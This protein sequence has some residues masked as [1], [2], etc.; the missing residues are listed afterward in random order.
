MAIVPPPSFLDELKNLKLYI[1]YEPRT[2]YDKVSYAKLDTD[3]IDEDGTKF[4]NTQKAII[5]F[6]DK[7][8]IDKPKIDIPQEQIFKYDHPPA[9]ILT[10]PPLPQNPPKPA[11]TVA[12]AVTL[13]PIKPIKP[14]DY[15]KDIVVIGAGPVGLWFVISLLESKSIT[16]IKS[17]TVL[18]KRKTSNYTTRKQQFFIENE[19][20]NKLPEDIKTELL[21]DPD[22]CRIFRPNRL[23]KSYCYKPATGFPD[24]KT[25]TTSPDFG[26]NDYINGYSIMINKLQE[27]FKKYIDKQIKIDKIKDK[28]SNK[29]IDFIFDATVEKIEDKKIVYKIHGDVTEKNK[30]FDT[31]VISSGKIDKLG[32]DMGKY[33]IKSEESATDTEDK[34]KLK[35]LYGAAINITTNIK[36]DTDSVKDQNV[37]DYFN[38]SDYQHRFRFFRQQGINLYVGINL[39]KDEYEKYKNLKEG[40]NNVFKQLSD[41]LKNENEI[42]QN[43][44]GELKNIYDWIATI[45]S[46]YTKKDFKKAGTDFA[47]GKGEFSIFPIKLMSATNPFVKK[48]NNNNVYVI[49]D[50]VNSPHFFSMYG[51][52][53]GFKTANMVSDII[54]R[55][56]NDV[57]QKEYKTF[58]DAEK[59]NLVQKAIDVTIDFGKCVD[60]MGTLIGGLDINKMKDEMKQASHPENDIDFDKLNDVDIC[61][62]YHAFNKK[63]VAG[64]VAP[65]IAHPQPPGAGETIKVLT[66]NVSWEAMSANTN[67]AKINKLVTAGK[68][69]SAKAVA[70][71]CRE[72]GKTDDKDNKC[73]LNVASIIEGSPDLDF[74]GLQEAT[75]WNLIKEKST[76]LNKMK[77]IHHNLPKK[78]GSRVEELVSF[79][80]PKKF[81]F[82]AAYIGE[83]QSRPYQIIYL[84]HKVSLVIYA[85]INVHL[86]HKDVKQDMLDKFK[87]TTGNIYKLIDETKDAGNAK[88]L[89]IPEELMTP[90]SI[91]ALNTA[92]ASTGANIKYEQNAFLN[93]I[94]NTKHIIFLGDTNDQAGKLY[95]NYKPFDM[96]MIDPTKVKPEFK[97]LATNFKGLQVSK[98]G[99][100]LPASCCNSSAEKKQTYTAGNGKYT[101]FGDYILVSDKLDFVAGQG[102][103]ILQKLLDENKDFENFPTSDHL[104]VYAE[105]S[106]P[107]DDILHLDL[108]ADKTGLSS[109]YNFIADNKDNLKQGDLANTTKISQDI[110]DTIKAIYDS[111]GWTD[112]NDA[113]QTWFPTTETDAAQASYYY[114]KYTTDD[115]TIFAVTANLTSNPKSIDANA[116]ANNNVDGK[117]FYNT[118]AGN[119]TSGT[120]IMINNAMEPLKYS[121]ALQ[122][123]YYHYL[124]KLDG[125]TWKYTGSCP[126]GNDCCDE[127]KEIGYDILYDMNSEKN[128]AVEKYY[129]PYKYNDGSND[130]Y[131]MVYLKSNKID[132]IDTIPDTNGFKKIPCVSQNGIG[133]YYNNA[134]GV[135]VLVNALMITFIAKMAHTKIALLNNNETIKYLT[136]YM[137]YVILKYAKYLQDTFSVD[138]DKYKNFIGEISDNNIV[139]DAMVNTSDNAY[140]DTDG[141]YFKEM[142]TFITDLYG[143]HW[144]IPMQTPAPADTYFLNIDW[145]ESNIIIVQ[146]QFD[147]N[148]NFSGSIYCRDTIFNPKHL[149]IIR[150]FYKLNNFVISF[151]IGNNGHW[152][153]YT[154]NKYKNA[155]GN[156]EK[157]FLFLDSINYDPDKDISDNIKKLLEKDTYEDFIIEILNCYSLA[158]DNTDV[159]YLKYASYIENMISLLLNDNVL[160]GKIPNYKDFVKKIITRIISV[161]IKYYNTSTATACKNEI[162]KNLD[163]LMVQNKDMDIKAHYYNEI[164]RNKDIYSQHCITK[165]NL[166][167]KNA[168]H[169]LDNTIVIKGGSRKLTKTNQSNQSTSSNPPN[170]SKLTKTK[171]H[172]TQ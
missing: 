92:L 42:K 15:N 69:L 59:K 67:E 132:T 154:V 61:L 99:T 5:D 170:P 171:H 88:D 172:K 19:F 58:I 122:E 41:L 100:T 113:T 81:K 115:K 13:V 159:K 131:Y 164:V 89:K 49:G 108:P 27:V 8:P 73:L 3:Y 85:F 24:A 20:F 53:S 124:N 90:A 107:D 116:F 142:N 57:A 161:D 60:A 87:F 6:V 140:D 47:I 153:C 152:K 139:D 97:A 129:K 157:Q 137:R 74:I 102:N 82:I 162:I 123:L 2:I 48:A 138:V 169:T 147:N 1:K 126:K 156:I 50:A 4:A 45:I 21:K 77:Y 14:I 119:E 133:D 66:Y 70:E 104:P 103:V 158:T 94:Y 112:P 150:N 64:V 79:Y 121:L 62:M 155:S 78:G 17:L 71:I 9:K 40:G 163:I 167:T 18:E 65:P 130:F 36:L 145:L 118:I 76:K 86:P 91:T 141:Q 12:V 120:A 54:A 106:L 84:K 11:K 52:N 39:S 33:D 10:N 29:K 166:E 125:N 56:D 30:S 168:I 34:K 31:L 114:L 144:C 105:I 43:S 148:P 28:F 35:D 80:N 149:K 25:P 151:I 134:C 83:V 128:G 63:P 72:A 55:D 7:L 75:N 98:K 44:P 136:R 111:K 38:T 93:E 95:E 101:L 135:F 51:V 23:I 117:D 160:K 37:I 109:T 26:K 143:F 146:D 127:F 16:K 165:L 22:A 46:A 68:I 96:I 110:Y 32:I